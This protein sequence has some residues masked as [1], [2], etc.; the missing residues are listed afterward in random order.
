MPEVT[1]WPSPNGLPI[2][3]TKSPTSARSESAT[4]IWVRFAALT[5]STATSDPGSLP[6]T[7]AVSERLSSSVTVIS[8]AFSITCAFVMM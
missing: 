8:V 4:G 5:C 1:V 6:T 7:F 3:T 2:A